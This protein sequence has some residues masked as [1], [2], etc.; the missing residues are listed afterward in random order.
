MKTIIPALIG[1]NFV[2]YLLQLSIQGFT[3]TF[4]LSRSLVLSEPWRLLTS[5]FLHSEATFI[6]ILFNMLVLFYFGP[7]L[8]R[9]LGVRNFIIF[10]LTSGIVASLAYIS[11][12]PGFGL[13]AS[14]A[15]LAILGAVAILHPRIEVYLFFFI[16]MKLWVL[17]LCIGLFDFIG[18]FYPMLNIGHAAHLGGLL[19]G[20][21]IGKFLQ[22]N[23]QT[24][25]RRPQRRML[26]QNDL[27]AYMRTGRI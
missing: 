17:V 15:L 14:G 20:V 18:L 6:H 26:S 8:E 23:Q 13:G 22:K 2:I 4:I 3:E 11:H 21:L 25:Q 9:R 24:F 16:P 27:D 12:T 10:Y 1:L 5:V 7:V 19:F